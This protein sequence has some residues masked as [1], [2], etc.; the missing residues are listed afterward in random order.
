MNRPARGP[1]PCR[2]P[3]GR[4]RRASPPGVA[5]ACSG[6]GA[7]GR[8]ARLTF[9]P[10]LHHERAAD[11]EAGWLDRSG[12]RTARLQLRAT[13]LTDLPVLQ[14]TWADEQIRRQAGGVFADH[15]LSPSR[16]DWTPGAG[17]FT[18]TLLGGLVVGF[19][20]LG[21][22]RTGDVELSYTFLPEYRGLGYARE[23]V[24]A[25]LA[26]AFDTNP[27]IRRIVAV[28]RAS[29]TR[30]VRLLAGLGMTKIDEFVEFGALQVM[31]A[32]TP[33]AHRASGR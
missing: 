14:R 17:E 8:I 15:V 19:C 18:V 24:A 23:A 3:I 30:S 29:N 26:W 11:D 21:R 16:E 5:A 4:R 12:I 1:R 31:Y 33:P 13:Q 10:V 22:Y 2:A 6:V 28:T 9:R 32:A 20:R 27:G 25:V 7:G